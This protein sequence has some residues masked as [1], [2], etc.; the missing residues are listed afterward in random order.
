MNRRWPLAAFALLAA[1]GAVAR[2]GYA[3]GSTPYERMAPLAQYLIPDRATEIALARS[4][5]PPAIS[6]HAKVMVLTARGYETPEAGTNGFTCLVE[7]AWMKS[8]DD[9]GFWSTKFRAPVCYNPVASRSVLPYTLFRTGLVLAGASKTEILKR[10]EAA[11]GSQLPGF[12]AGS[13][14]YMMSKEQYL[15]DDGRPS[16]HPHVMFYAP[17]AAGADA[18]S[19][20]GADR[21]GSPV[22]FDT[23]GRILPEPWALFFVPVSHWSDGSLAPA[24]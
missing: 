5:A 22:I 21:A 23:S 19:D 6:M 16:W 11:V 7:R 10:V 24:A 20:W 12:E 9:Q 14:A 3:Q 1:L 13:M 18:G 15:T 4:A 17:K 2:P 8:F